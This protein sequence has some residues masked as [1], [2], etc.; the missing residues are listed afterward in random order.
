M[1][2]TV[3]GKL[4]RAALAAAEAIGSG[5]E[6][7]APRTPLEARLHAIWSDVLSHTDFGVTDNFFEIGGDSLRAMRM[8]SRV[9]QIAEWELPLRTVFELPTLETL[10]IEILRRGPAAKARSIPQRPRGKDRL[11]LSYAQERLWFLWKMNPENVAYNIA[12]AVRLTGALDIDALRAALDQTV[13]RHESLRSR[14][15]EADGIAYQVVEPR[16][17]YDWVHHDLSNLSD[18]LRDGTAR[19]Q[20]RN[21]VAGAFDLQQ[22]PLLR[23]VLLR[24]S[25]Q[26]HMLQLVVHHAVADGWSMNILI[27]EI[28]IVYAAALRKAPVVLPAMPIQYADYASWQREQ[29]DS[30]ALLAQLQYWRDRLGYDHPVMELP[31]DHARREDSNA[32]A[33]EVSL[34]L[35]PE[36]I[37]KL[38]ELSLRCGT[39]LFTTLLAAFD[40][41]LHRYSGQSDI[42]IGVPVSGRQQFETEPV[43][44]LFVN[45]LV[46]RTEI[47]GSMRLGELLCQVHENVVGAQAN[48][49]LPFEKLVA[50]LQPVRSLNHSP[51]FQ[52]MFNL[53]QTK[54][55][56]SVLLPGLEVSKLMSEVEQAQFDLTLNAQEADTG[57]EL[58]LCYARRLFERD[59][60]LRMLQA[61]CAVLQQMANMAGA[62]ISSSISNIKVV[63]DDPVSPA[64]SYDFLPVAA[65]I[66]AQAALRAEAE[67]V[68]CVGER[69]SYG[70]LEAWSN[71]LGRRLKRLGVGAD[72]RV[73]LCVERSLG[74][75]AGVLGILKAGGAYVPLDPAYPQERLA[76]ML[77]DSGIRVVVAD[78]ASAEKRGGLLAGFDV[79]LL[80]DVPGR[81][82][83][84]G[85]A[86]DADAAGWVGPVGSVPVGD[87]A[88]A[89]AAGWVEPVHPEQ[90]AY[91]IYTSGSTGRPKG[92]G[93]THR[94]LARLLDA[95]AEWYR[96]GPDDVWTLFHSYA[97]DFSVWEL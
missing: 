19:D 67:A 94:N 79:V 96:F 57:L 71:R 64:A 44:G 31:V 17:T 78:R 36:T 33:G 18:D 70:A 73:G 83:P 90:L 21:A 58:T 97:F 91:V 60:A 92:V 25:S 20:L 29:S 54:Q 88:D 56:D 89:D 28:P 27:E 80:E 32:A 12:G 39:T 81:N 7:T 2:L 4:D 51:L 34:D 23:M 22:G 66:T 13:L 45:T 14:F 41:L 26:S 63:N 68:S 53:F 59:T 75:V 38:R 47:T 11:P 9:R 46:I 1:P 43:V 6:R 84:F 48:Q 62:G 42:R 72:I 74:L 55:T 85:D 65:R 82:M 24:L 86:A 77:A 8:V 52:V 50:D 5:R 40:I 95:T 3:N 37:V 10:A 35:D 49:D 87:A 30:A 93:V 69:L 16:P 61:Y 15:E 76:E